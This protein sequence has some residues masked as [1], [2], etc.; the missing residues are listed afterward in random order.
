VGFDCGFIVDE[1]GCLSMR[2]K[3]VDMAGEKTRIVF[4]GHGMQPLD[5]KI[6]KLISV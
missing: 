1:G 2:C 6:N 3:G 5:E 4:S